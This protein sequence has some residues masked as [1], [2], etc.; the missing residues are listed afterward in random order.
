MSRL[1]QVWTGPLMQ[2]LDRIM[3]ASISYDTFK[4]QNI[5]CLWFVNYVVT[6]MNNDIAQC[7]AFRLYPSFVAGTLSEVQEINL[8]FLSNNKVIN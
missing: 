6:A 5:K 1:D 7:G 4:I 8:Y 2:K 3:G